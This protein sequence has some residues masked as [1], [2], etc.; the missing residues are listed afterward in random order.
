MSDPPPAIDVPEAGRARRRWLLPAAGLAAA[1]VVPL[2]TVAATGPETERPAARPAAVPTPLPATS[3]PPT[4]GAAAPSATPDPARTS[5]PTAS[6]TAVPSRTSVP[7]RR[8]AP[9]RSTTTSA[10]RRSATTTTPK[11]SCTP[12]GV[13]DVVQ[14]VTYGVAKVAARTDGESTN[15]LCPGERIRVFWATYSRTADGGAKLY[16][17]QVHYLDR[18]AP[19][20]TMRL[21]LPGS[22]GQSWYV[23]AGN[24]SIPQTLKPGVVPF[25]RGK[26]NWE[27]GAG[28]C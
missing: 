18:S 15:Q 3:L 8:P 5:T 13:V 16:G 6:P 22:C 1:V 20:W 2:V 27:T 25:G 7:T 28:A 4:T 21:A 23:V 14:V 24:W 12:A 11:P 10:P 9:A 17:S 19:T 26:L